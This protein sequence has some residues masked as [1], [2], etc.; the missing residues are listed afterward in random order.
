MNSILK[1][2]NV[3]DLKV[4]E[5]KASRADEV[6][7]HHQWEVSFDLLRVL[8]FSRKASGDR[9]MLLLFYFIYLFIFAKGT[10]REK[11]I[12]WKAPSSSGME[13]WL[14]WS[15]VVTKV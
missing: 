9:Q 10:L 6:N 3:K 4:N 11:F 8:D 7:H 15:E 1:K 12:F 5:K 14:S 2:K 13:D